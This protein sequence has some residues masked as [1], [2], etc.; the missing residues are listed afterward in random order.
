[1]LKCLHNISTGKLVSNS[2]MMHHIITGLCV[3]GLI[4]IFK[5]SFIISKAVY[6]FLVNKIKTDLCQLK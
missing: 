6:H 2:Y 5:L 3:W 4:Y 1:M